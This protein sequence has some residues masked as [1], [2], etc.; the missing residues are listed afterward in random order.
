MKDGM[1]QRRLP[2][3]NKLVTNK[4]GSAT[5][6]VAVANEDTSVV[7]GLGQTSAQHASL[8]TALKE[9]AGGERQ[10]EIELLLRLG[11]HAETGQT[12]KE[13]LTLE[14]TLGVLRKH[15]NTK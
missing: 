4:N 5:P 7:D 9:L 13:G 3:L 15:N 10:H 1:L 2:T 11:E 6:D 8:Q 14:H 12:A